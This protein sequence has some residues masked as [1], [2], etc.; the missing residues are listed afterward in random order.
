MT[1]Y[2]SN[3]IFGRILRGDMPCH[4]VYE[5]SEVLAFMDVM[6]QTDGHTLVIPK[7]GSR[8]LL[9]AD[10]EVLAATIRRVQKVAG[11]V[12]S[13]MGADGVRIMQFNGAAAGQTVF[14]LH[15]HI[16]PMYDGAKVRPHGGPM[17]DHGLLAE[18]ARKIAAAL[19]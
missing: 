18:Q 2:D 3:N 19:K 8:D 17:A 10:P 5:D 14:H 11:A 13:A 1:S 7:S 6:P 4:R 12:K 15:F 9:D 16:M